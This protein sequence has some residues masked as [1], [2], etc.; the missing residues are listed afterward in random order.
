M[1]TFSRFSECAASRS[2]HKSVPTKYWG[3]IGENGDCTF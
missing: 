2:F 3:L 1:V